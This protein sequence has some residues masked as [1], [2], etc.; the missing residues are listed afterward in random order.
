M[1]NFPALLL[2]FLF[3]FSFTAGAQESGFAYGTDQ[4]PIYY[5]TFGS[6]KPLLII[7]GGPGMN[8][9]GFE[10]LA[11]ELSKKYKTII[12]DQR[13]TG[14]SVL[15]TTDSTSITMDL[16]IA[17]IECLRKKLKIKKWAVLGHSFGGMLA[18]YYMT[19]HPEAIDRVILSASG[20]IDMG[21]LDYA[22]SSINSKLT[23]AQLDSV[24]YWTDRINN[25][26]TT[27]Y[28]RLQRGKFLAPAYVF[29]EK[30]MPVI[31]ERLT[32]SNGTVNGLIWQDLSKI[33]YNCAEKLKLFT[34]PVLI[35][36]GKQDIIKEETAERAHQVLKN[37]RV[38]LME[39][40]IHYGWIDN[41]EVYFKEVY[42]FLG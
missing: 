39:H 5:R 15:K 16:M 10:G 28:A 32:Q 11:A 21:L 42:A 35:I 6:G 4:A 9:N 13:G 8:S 31:A 20:G 38:V 7:N 34:K 24:S 23:K 37:S 14:K 27:H 18:S 22:G 17:D 29:D 36:Q 41:R 25:G 12:Y 40:C 19:K 26:D 33:G 3:L 2:F 30:A 1:K